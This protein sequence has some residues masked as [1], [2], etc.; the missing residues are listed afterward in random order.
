MPLLQELAHFVSPSE[1]SMGVDAQPFLSQGVIDTLGCIVLGAS[2]ESALKAMRAARTF[3]GMEGSSAVYGTGFS[4]SKPVA[5]FLNAVAGHAFDFDDWEISG[6]THPSVVLVSA[7]LAVADSKTSAQ[8]LADGYLAGYEVIARLGEALTLEHYKQGWHSTATLGA[9]GAAASVARLLGGD[10]TVTLN[11]MSLAIS[12]A[13]GYTC[14]FG[15]DAKPLQ[16]GFAAETGVIAAHLAAAGATGQAHILSHE[17]GMGA[18]MANVSSTRMDEIAARL[19]KDK[20]AF[21]QYGLAIKPW[22]NCSYA[23]RVMTAAR[24]MIGRLPAEDPITAIDLYL[25]DF[26]ASILPF[27]APT[28]KREAMFSLPFAVAMMFEEKGLTLDHL[29]SSSWHRPPIVALMKKTSIHPLKV[30]KPHLN[31]DPDQPDRVKVTLQS[32]LAIEQSCVYPLGA[33]QNPMSYDQVMEKF[34]ANVVGLS[35]CAFDKI[36]GWIDQTLVLDA[37]S[38]LHKGR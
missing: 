5:A 22:P 19:D 14:Q 25:P 24:E 16:A 1:F 12:R 8:H 11:A 3:G 27:D 31:Y 6:N 4:A 34:H 17:R 10:A 28:T 35:G 15:T 7:L 9:V 26:H 33:M 18:L 29:T 37:F 2:E 32:G 20:P 36:G 38:S 21:A 23:H 30:S 13:V